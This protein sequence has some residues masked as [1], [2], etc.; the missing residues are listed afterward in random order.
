MPRSRTHRGK[1]AIMNKK[2]LSIIVIICI[3]ASVGGSLVLLMGPSELR[4][5]EVTTSFL[6]GSVSLDNSIVGA[7]VAVYTLDGK[8]IFEENDST[9]PSGSFLIEVKSLPSEF[10]IIATGG[11][12]DNQVFTGTVVREVH[13]FDENTYYNLNAVTTLISA[14]RE[15]HSE[16]SYA[17]AENVV[18]EFLGIE[19]P[20]NITDLI[21]TPEYYS[22]TFSHDN[23]MDE[24]ENA[25][26]FDAF[27]DN[28]VGEI[29]IEVENHLFSSP[30]V[31]VGFG[32][33]LN[34][35]KYCFR[36]IGGTVL[37]LTEGHDI[38]WVFRYV[39]D[40][41]GQKLDAMS[42]QLDQIQ[43]TLRELKDGQR[44]ISRKLDAIS[45]QI[46]DEF[47]ALRQQLQQMEEELARVI[48]EEGRVNQLKTRRGQL[49]ESI[50]DPASHIMSAFS[51]LRDLS[52]DTSDAIREN[53]NNRLEECQDMANQY[54]NQILHS[55]HGIRS[56]L[57]QLQLS[58]SDYAGEEGLLNIW[59]T[60]AAKGATSSDDM[61]Y[62]YQCFEDR[63]AYLLGLELQGVTLVL[64]AI[65][66][67]Y[68]ENST[69]AVSFWNEW[70]PIFE[71]QINEFV[72]C[73]EKLACSRIDTVTARELGKFDSQAEYSAPVMLQMAD[74]FSLELSSGLAGENE[75][76]SGTGVLTARI[77]NFP[78]FTGE[79]LPDS[80]DLNFLYLMGGATEIVYTAENIVRRNGTTFPDSWGDAYSYEVVRYD[81]GRV[82]LGSYRLIDL[83]IELLRQLDY[84]QTTTIASENGYGT[85]SMTAYL[86]S[87]CT[88]WGSYGTGD[89]QFNYPSGIAVDGNRNVYVADT[90]NNR[91]QKF[92][93]N[94]NFITT[95]G[96]Y[97]S[98]DGHFAAPTGIAVD[99]S[100]YVY[101]SDQAHRVQKFDSNGN[102]ISKF[103]SW[104]SG[105]GQFIFPNWIAVDSSGNVYISDERNAR[106]QKFDSN[107]NFL[108]KWGS[109]GSG[110]GQFNWPEGIGVDSSGN[111]YVSDHQA[112]GHAERRVQKFDSNGTFIAKWGSEGTGDGQ[113]HG[114]MGI[115]VDSSGYV[116]ISDANTDFYTHNDSMQKFD[117]NGNFIA[118]WGSYG[119]G[120]GQ[121]NSPQGVAVDAGGKVYVA[122]AGN[123][124]IQVFRGPIVEVHTYHTYG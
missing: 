49:V 107:G 100:G 52:E 91:I 112:L 11:T 99:S 3:L 48:A 19:S 123:N 43:S 104:G 46:A 47:A 73:V 83:D 1:A 26:G 8:K 96:S 121:F 103:G 87:S 62:I 53:D 22:Y 29:D 41:D 120:N 5:G 118:K 76:T 37:G 60:L 10:K 78:H 58:I 57:Y 109:Y 106:V 36:A 115:A 101:V 21:D 95:W 7:T 61:A 119:S 33:V 12:L 89:G 27:V 30:A 72:S 18:E 38:G 35:F 42:E 55:T 31:G 122:D 74:R 124:R 14:Y 17:E 66:G 84:D 92:D 13:G 117:S 54:I 51:S 63:F 108:A 85:R 59:A 71:S 9:H 44:E 20:D 50:K 15:N 4:E 116:Y 2:P 65:H 56:D 105:D 110:N 111:V 81:F 28:L 25:G 79:N 23:F 114:P 69:Q 86:P 90:N 16:V 24:A 67:K 97:G 77:V 39:F 68:G 82:P 32:D 88:V 94:G 98:A 70:E 64:D 80:I 40:P 113:F 6:M 102:F 34:I 75:S 45:K 93:S